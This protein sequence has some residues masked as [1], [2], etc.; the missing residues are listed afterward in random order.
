MTRPIS[1]TLLDLWMAEE[2]INGDLTA[3]SVDLLIGMQPA[4]ADRRH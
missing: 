4:D 2:D 1:G 3:S